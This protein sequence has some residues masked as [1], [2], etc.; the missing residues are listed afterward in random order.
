MS[1]HEPAI[2]TE[3]LTPDGGLLMTHVR[4]GGETGRA[5]GR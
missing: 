1:A 5:D 3:H 4:T 2:D